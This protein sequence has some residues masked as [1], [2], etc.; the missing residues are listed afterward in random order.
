[1]LTTT[2]FARFRDDRRVRRRFER[3]E[4]SLRARD[5]SELPVHLQSA[6]R[7]RLDQLRQY[8]QRGIFPRNYDHPGH[9]PS[10]IDRE[11]R[12][13]AVAHL[14][15]VSGHDQL[16]RQIARD[17]NS[18]YVRDLDLPEVEAWAAQTGLS[19][20]ELGFIQPSYQCIFQ[21]DKFPYTLYHLNGVLTGLMSIL[22]MAGGLSI[23]ASVFNFFDVLRKRGNRWLGVLSIGTGLT[24]IGAGAIYFSA[25]RTY[26]ADIQHYMAVFHGLNPVTTSWRPCLQ[27]LYSDNP[28][29]GYLSNVL[30]V[31]GA[32]FYPAIF[33]IGLGAIVLGLLALIS[34]RQIRRFRAI[35]TPALSTEPVRAT[36]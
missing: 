33:I 22:Y 4:H 13:C 32:T 24:L 10:F 16:A 19:K 34:G 20:E 1:M 35:S 28:M 11:G 21:P 12:V 29:L 9:R 6:R 31:N 15:I 30:P 8:Y 7:T 23:F 18:T 36:E 5:I 26:Q 27:L 2:W 25:L 3:V 14:M 17:C